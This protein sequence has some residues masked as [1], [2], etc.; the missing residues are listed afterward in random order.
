[1]IKNHKTGLLFLLLISFSLLLSTSLSANVR[2]DFDACFPHC[3]TEGILTATGEQVKILEAEHQKHF[4]IVGKNGIRRQ[5]AWSELLPKTT[6]PKE[7]SAVDEKTVAYFAGAM[8]MKSKTDYLLWT[9]LSRFQTYVL[10]YGD[11]GWHV[12][13]TLPCSLGDNAHPT[14]SGTYEVDYKCTSIGKENLYLCRHALCFYGSYM[15]HS[16]L[17][18]W[19]GS[20]LID[21]RLGERISHGCIRLSPADSQWLYTKIPIGTTVFIR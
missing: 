20:H 11:E 15:Y 21:A 7:I 4:V 5:V 16:V 14:P 2:E 19:G 9:D 8:G 10:E 6:Y 1:M 12:L 17:Y 3:F 13:K 18:D